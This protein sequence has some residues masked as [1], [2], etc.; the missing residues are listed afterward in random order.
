M[1]FSRKHPRIFGVVLLLVGIAASAYLVHIYQTGAD[2]PRYV[3]FIASVGLI[4]GLAVLVEP[5][6]TYVDGD[7]PAELI[8]R[9]VALGIGVISVIVGLYV[10]YSIFGAWH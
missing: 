6:L 2:L 4:Y 3:P 5:R 8:F 1:H 10:D 7:D 9:R